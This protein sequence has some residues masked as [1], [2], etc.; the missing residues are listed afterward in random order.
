LFFVFSQSELAMTGI[1][2]NLQNISGDNDLISVPRDGTLDTL[3]T[4]IFNVICK[5]YP[6][7]A[8][9]EDRGGYNNL[10]MAVPFRLVFSGRNLW[11][12]SRTLADLGIVENSTLYY[13]WRLRGRV[14]E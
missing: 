14:V 2:L 4:V 8:D 12:G 7:I 3:I 11:D 6:H 5:N 13:I 1:V 9:F 10:A